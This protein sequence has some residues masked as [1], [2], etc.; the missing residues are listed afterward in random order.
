MF[1]PDPKDPKFIADQKAAE[2]KKTREKADYEKKLADGK[3]KVDGFI[4][5]LRA[6][7]LRDAGRQ[8]PLDQ[9]GPRALVEP[10][11]PPARKGPRQGRRRLSRRGCP[12]GFRRLRPPRE[13]CPWRAARRAL[14]FSANRRSERS[15]P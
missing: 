7:V 14:H 12:R 10:K 5:A 8:L 4:A 9:P 1:A 11:K 15:T 13:A 6:V 3:K 2:D